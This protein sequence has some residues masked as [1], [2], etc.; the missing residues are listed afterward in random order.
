MRQRVEKKGRS[1]KAE[2]AVRRSSPPKYRNPEN[3]LQTWRGT[4]CPPRWLQDKLNEGAE[5]ENF[6]VK[7][8]LDAE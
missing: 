2:R 1:K 3:P 4:G 7:P 8:V 5:L 6:L